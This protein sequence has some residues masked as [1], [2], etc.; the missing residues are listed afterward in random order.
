MNWLRF[1]IINIAVAS[2][3][4][5]AADKTNKSY[6]LLS[7]YVKKSLIE[8]YL[9]PEGYING[10]ELCQEARIQL[11]HEY[12]IWVTSTKYPEQPQAGTTLIYAFTLKPFVEQWPTVLFFTGGPGSSGRALTFDLPETNIIYFD[13]RGI[14]CSRPE[15]HKD[16]I[17]PQFYSSLNTADDALAILKNLNLDQVTVYGHSYGTVS[18]TI[19]ASKY[20]QRV[21][22][23]ILEGVISDAGQSLIQSNRKREILQ[24]Y[25]SKLNLETQNKIIQVSRSLLPANWFSKVGGAIL[26]L[27]DGITSL[28]RYIENILKQPEADIKTAIGYFYSETVED[29]LMFYSSI[30]MGM[31]S[32]QETAASNSYVGNS[33]EFDGNRKL[34]Y[35]HENELYERYCRPLKLTN[36]HRNLYHAKD[37]P[38]RIP[39]YYFI[40]E[41]D[42][43]TDLDQGLRHY[44]TVPQDDRHLLILKL[45][46]HLPSLSFLKEIRPCDPLKTPQYC[47]SQKI[48]LIQAE[49]LKSIIHKDEINNQ[50][51]NLF[52]SKNPNPW[53]YYGH[54]F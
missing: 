29:D 48:N 35:N 7:S 16:F 8:K 22:Q 31:I 51:L 27:N 33:M 43:A 30:V 24:S 2:T 52:N 13:Q 49:I 37:Y 40:G 34:N 41:N 54:G 6:L 9:D 10:K 15:K 44:K 3:F 23:L 12:P 17:N 11:N 39:V 21:K 28:S 14:A 46:G 47:E 38:V 19:F 25:F 50:A 45:G 53:I 1:V 42:A 5:Y 20:P 32:C 36:H 18:A 4:V 26:Y